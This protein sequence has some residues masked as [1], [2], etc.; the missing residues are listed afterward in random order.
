[1]A[2]AIYWHPV[3][4]SA[5][6]IGVGPDG[7]V[8]M[9]RRDGTTANSNALDWINVPASAAR[10]GVGPNNQPWVVNANGT[11][12]RRDGANWT[13]LSGYA[14]DIAVGPS[15]AAWIIG[16]DRKI[17]S[18]NGSGWTLIGGQADFIA[19]GPGEQVWAAVAGGAIFRR[20][21]ETLTQLPPPPG[22]AF[23]IAVGSDGT[24]WAIG[25]GNAAYS[26][27][28]ATGSWID[29]GLACSSLSVTPEGRAWAVKTD[30]SVVMQSIRCQPSE[31]RDW[32]NSLC[33]RYLGHGPDPL[34]L[35]Y[36]TGRL[37]ARE[38]PRAQQEQEFIGYQ[39]T[40]QRAKFADYDFVRSL[41][42]R[43]L[44]HAADAA[45]LQFHAQRLTSGQI[46]RDNLEQEFRT[47]AEAVQHGPTDDDAFVRS[48]FA[49]YI[50]RDPRDQVELSWHVPR[51]TSGSMTRAALEAEFASC[52]EAK[53]HARLRD[54]DFLISLFYRY[55]GRAPGDSELALHFGAMLGGR[56]AA[57][58]DAEFR[59]C[60]EAVAYR[61]S[62]A[63]LQILGAAYSGVPA[64]QE[65]VTAKVAALVRDNRLWL[66]VT[67]AVFNPP[68]SNQGAVIG[69][70]N[71]T[72]CILFR[73]GNC[74]PR[75]CIAPAGGSAL[76]IP[77][78]HE[79][80]LSPAPAPAAAP[81]A[82]AASTA[83]PPRPKLRI[84]GAVYGRSN[85][86]AR[87]RQLVSSDETLY[88]AATDAVWGPTG[89]IAPLPN[90]L[91]IFYQQ[92]D[93]P[94]L[95][96]VAQPNTAV[97]LGA[98]PLRIL[99]A[100]FGPADVTAAVSANVRNG[101]LSIKAD[102]RLV[103]QDPWPRYQKSLVV[104]YQYGSLYPCVAVV[105]QD[106]TL[107][108]T[109]DSVAMPRGT[110]PWID[111]PAGPGLN[112]MGAAFGLADVTDILL[113]QRGNNELV[114]ISADSPLLP[115]SWPGVRKT[116]V[117]VFQVDGGRP[118]LQIARQSWL[119]DP[120]IFGGVAAGLLGT[121]P[122]PAETLLMAGP[123]IL[124]AA[125]GPLDVT[126]RV[127]SLVRDGQLAIP[128]NNGIFGD[129]WQGQNKALVVIY[130]YGLRA[131]Q[132]AIA[133]EGGTLQI[134]TQLPANY[135]MPAPQLQL[136]GAAYGLADVS[137]AARS[138]LDGDRD[139]VT[140]LWV[141]YLGRQPNQFEI[142]YYVDQLTSRVCDRDGLEQKVAAWD[143]ARRHG[144]VTDTDFVGSLFALYLGRPADAWGLQ[145]HTQR[146]TSGQISRDKL[147]EEFRTC[148]EAQQH[149]SV[150]RTFR[151]DNSW[152]DSWPGETKYL[153]LCHQRGDGLPQL[154]IIAESS[155][156]TIPVLPQ[157]VRTYIRAQV[158]LLT[159]YKT[160]PAQ[161]VRV[162]Q[163]GM[164]VQRPASQT[165][166]SGTPAASPVRQK[167]VFQVVLSPV[168]PDGSAV[169]G[170]TL[171]TLMAEGEMDILSDASGQTVQYHLLP[172]VPLQ[173][174]AARSGRCRISVEP[175]AGQ[176]TC[177]LLRARWD[178][179]PP[180]VWAVIAPDLDLHQQLATLT[181]ERLL[182]PPAGKTSPLAGSAGGVA[183]A[184]ALAG[185][186]NQAMGRLATSEVR[187]R[188]SDGAMRLPIP[189]ALA[190]ATVPDNSDAC[191]PP[192]VVAPPGSTVSRV[193]TTGAGY[194]AGSRLMPSA[195]LPPGTI[196]AFSIGDIFNP[197][198]DGFKRLGE[199]IASTATSL[200]SAVISGNIFSFS[201]EG[202]MG[203]LR[204]A[205]SLAAPVLSLRDDL[206]SSATDFLIDNTNGLFA[207][208]LS[209]KNGVVSVVKSA[210]TQIE[211]V[212][213]V[214]VAF[215]KKLA[216]EL[217][218][219]IEFL[220]G[221]L[222]WGDVLETQRYLAQTIDSALQSL[223][224]LCASAGPAL[225]ATFD[226]LATLIAGS[227]ARPVSARHSVGEIFTGLGEAYEFISDRMDDFLDAV[228]VNVGGASGESSP[229]LDRIAAEL[230]SLGL[231]PTLTM[232]ALDSLLTDPAS[233]LDVFR[234]LAAGLVVS[235]K[236]ITS[237][238]LEAVAKAA[239][240]LR[241]F[242]NQ[243]LYVPVLTELIEVF[244]FRGQSE[245]TILNLITLLAG[246]AYTFIYKIEHGASHG[247]FHGMQPPS[248]PMP[249]ALP[250]A[251]P[252]A[253]S[254]L[255][256][257]FSDEPAA[258]NPQMPSETRVG[259]MITQAALYGLSALKGDLYSSNPGTGPLNQLGAACGALAS[260]I[261]ITMTL[262]NTAAF[263]RYWPSEIT[264]NLLGFLVSYYELKARMSKALIFAPLQQLLG[265]G[266]MVAA[267]VTGI[268]CLV[269]GI[270]NKDVVILHMDGQLF[271]GLSD[272]MATN[273]ELSLAALGAGAAFLG[274]SALKQM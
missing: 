63:P 31:D 22:G 17:Y 255:P 207:Y 178:E 189:V 179:M 55:L 51:L 69:Y 137:V 157:I 12:S 148:P 18:W 212:A 173:I 107:S 122:H 245:L 83:P 158:R 222:N 72:L 19:V 118:I 52:D 259:L 191:L 197:I 151:A 35:D 68:V 260:S 96:Y 269:E 70:I 187:V 168:R 182:N 257:S 208:V 248:G 1:M 145:Y 64:G 240:L 130:R 204:A 250:S 249:L 37:L 175:L 89:T 85:V 27:D 195:P 156:V 125:Y 251:T 106:Q 211:D 111:R 115:D 147:A 132:V 261:S 246:A 73:Y 163:P 133:R 41:C 134:S 152:G 247:P 99:G 84:L 234:S 78:P 267:L 57:D 206:L 13:L 262:A 150:L 244:I 28:A 26:R 271:F 131:P 142:G 16:T 94:P 53:A 91:S 160:D 48:L 232:S 226:S 263:Q 80:F 202:I 161:Q 32:V 82:P 199:Q 165:A 47:C 143:E 43:Y 258:Q 4:G 98:P 93:G 231:A 270:G 190:G 23:D 8:W 203:L 216:L 76:I 34:S 95:L 138:Q 139:F 39:E 224:P 273:K 81:A 20:D 110:N 86:T 149:T 128:V 75:L 192:H 54:R 223:P 265:C 209:V 116:L 21:G 205:E 74:P 7:D 252:A 127:A 239:P 121:P 237:S 11:I 215:V 198:G 272:V 25:A 159:D 227:G 164:V 5:K 241:S 214:A 153:V 136:M 254:T 256:L 56:S 36:H 184:H 185:M 117:A 229:E 49:R 201:P 114:S 181:P 213:R 60:P 225:T 50:G 217:K 3:S 183:Q 79:I 87:A 218:T 112:I 171:I 44:G 40:Q 243:R 242:F 6:D 236:N 220:L 235:L 101:T 97:Y 266:Q 167:G 109:P 174:A 264:Y 140:S 9:V 65:D 103:A 268:G 71:P 14:C 105:A 188:T 144:P 102:L 10:I 210:L 45:G 193:L 177:P 253:A 108:I 135:L 119:D 274:T 15:G 146:V 59:D 29:G 238:I 120:S 90:K 92:D 172:G 233:I 2:T 219:L 100:A 126:D 104:I 33:W 46:T 129:S 169:P 155:S 123:A 162:S 66:V 196:I 77:L 194:L 176:L 154:N 180:D 88:S 221:L 62:F 38:L 186:M 67:D 30:G 61:R 42:W 141:R 24:V 113:H 58:M 170:G 230:S 200:A 166:Q 124:G 228:G